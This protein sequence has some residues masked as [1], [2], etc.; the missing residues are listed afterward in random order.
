MR[1]LLL[2]MLSASL[3]PLAALADSSSHSG[4]LV[5]LSEPVAVTEHY[6]SFGG[7]VPDS[8]SPVSLAT[9][10]GSDDQLGKETVISTNIAKVCQKKGCFFIAREGEAVARV[11]FKDYGF[12]IPTDSRGKQVTLLGTVGRETLTPEQQAHAAADLGEKAGDMAPLEYNI[13]ASAIRVPR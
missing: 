3:I 11:T 5:R 12:F 2:L 13:V 1:T 6:E 9:A 10:L 8:P 4:K 7:L